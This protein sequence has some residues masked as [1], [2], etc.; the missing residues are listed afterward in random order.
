VLAVQDVKCEL[1]QTFLFHICILQVLKAWECR[2]PHTSIIG[3]QVRDMVG[4]LGVQAGR[5]VSTLVHACVVHP[6]LSY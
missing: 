1:F 4:E 5:N 6:I 2:V 3:N